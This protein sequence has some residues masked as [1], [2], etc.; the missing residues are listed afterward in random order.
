MRLTHDAVI[1]MRLAAA[2]PQHAWRMHET[3]FEL[4]HSGGTT[5]VGLHL[6]RS[7]TWQVRQSQNTCHKSHVTSR[8]EH[9]ITIEQLQ[10]VIRYSAG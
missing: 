1:D 10:T 5:P 7:V 8:T 6:Y 3:S 2:K 4:L 9:Q